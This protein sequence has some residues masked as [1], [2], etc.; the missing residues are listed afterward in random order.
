MR[1]K[2]QLL[3][4]HAYKVLSDESLRPM[5]LRQIHYELVSKQ[6]VENTIP[7]YKALSRALVKARKTGAIPWDWIE[8]RLRQP[9]TVSMWRDLS[10]LAGNVTRHYRRD[11]WLTQ[12]S[13]LEVWLEKDALSGVFESVLD[14]YGVTLNVGRGFDGW[15]SRHNAAERFKEW[16]DVTILY[17]GD[18][19][20]S[21]EAMVQSL[22]DSLAELESHPELIKCALTLDDIK[23]YNLPRN[24]AKKTDSRA[25]K[26]IE[27]YGDI[28]VELDAVPKQILRD[29]LVF[30]V[31]SRMDMD[32]FAEARAVEERERR[33][34]VETVEKWGSADI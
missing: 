9:R 24:F 29:R 28:S 1:D 21:G 16:D 6:L 10:H 8:D 22:R 34:L 18:F 4:K 5:T 23:R 25:K 12:S 17:F 15:D 14:R 32:A 33:Y 26:F 3:I 31:E 30:E 27:K 7:S 19:D 20:P 13:Y 2:T 11:V